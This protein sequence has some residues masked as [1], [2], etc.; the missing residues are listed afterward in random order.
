MLSLQWLFARKNSQP[1]L[2]RRSKHPRHYSALAWV[3]ALTPRVLLSA[4]NP[5]S[6]KSLNGSNGFRIHGLDP[7]HYD[8]RRVASAGDVNGD[9]FDD[10]IIQSILQEQHTNGN[11]RYVYHV[12]FG[13]PEGFAP[14]IELSSLNGSNGFRLNGI[15]SLDWSGC[16][17][18]S[19][20]DVNGDGFDDL[21][22]GACAG[23]SGECYL[24]F[25]KSSGFAPAMDISSFN[26]SNG[27]R[28]D[29]FDDHAS[30]GRSVGGAGDVN[31]DGFDDLII[32]NTAG[33]PGTVNEYRGESYVVFGK[34]KG[35][36][37]AMNLSSLNGSNGFQ[38]NGI[39]KGDNSGISV[40]SAGDVNGDGFD[41]LIIGAVHGDAGGNYS[42]ESY[43]VFGRSGSFPSKFDLSSL[44]GNNGFRLDGAEENDYSGS[45]VRSAGDMNGDGFDDL[46]IGVGVVRE[47]ATDSGESYVVFGKSSGFESALSLSTLDGSN[48]FRLNGIDAYDRCGFSVSGAGDV[49]GDGFDDL[50]I[51]APD[52]TLMAYDRGVKIF[53]TYRCGE[54]YIVYGKPNGYVPVLNLSTLD[55]FNG[56]RLDGAENSQRLG[57]SVSGGGDVNG[58]GFDDLIILAVGDNRWERSFTGDT[59]VVFGGNFTGG[60]E[61]QLG[62]V[63]ANTLTAQ[64]GSSLD[65]LIG[66]GGNDSLISDGGPD[67]LIGGQGNDI[68]AVPDSAFSS[69]RRLLGGNGTDTLRVDGHGVNLDLTRIQDNRIVDIEVV[70][71]T[72][73]GSNSLTLDAGEVLKISSHSNTLTVRRNFDDQVNI[74]N[75][76]ILGS[77]TH[78]GQ[79]S[80]LV[81]TQGAAKLLVQIPNV[82]IGTNDS[83]SFVLLYSNASASGTV[84]VTRTTNGRPPVNLGSFPMSSGL[85]LIGL[86]GTDLVRIVGTTGNDTITALSSVGMIVNGS[87]LSLNSIES[88]TLA[89]AA[90]NDIYKFDV[91]TTLGLFSLDESEGGTDTIDFSLTTK[92]PV[93]ISLANYG[94]QFVHSTNLRLNLGSSTSFENVIGGS[95]NDI[96]VG[97][98]AGNR[99]TG[100]SGYNILVG[101]NGNDFL[102]TG[103]GRDVLIGGLGR[104][105]LNGGGGDDVVI[106]G[107]TSFDENMTSLNVIRNE[108]TS[109]KSYTH[110]V[111]S[112]RTGVGSP[113]VSLR[114]KA[115]VLNDANE[116]DSLTGGI[117]TDWYFRAVDDAVTDLFAGEAIEV[118]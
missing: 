5:L 96:L 90:G 24:L 112:L 65:V 6:V 76:W 64:K 36:S 83:D 45:C 49:N 99:L 47:G 18:Q 91:D 79:D 57:W 92:V 26:G 93:N 16:D 108:W 109:A 46:I 30:T 52:A 10:V 67:V 66:G 29:G 74:G 95:Q 104:D 80:F 106:A 77:V 58:D 111:S 87:G 23:G 37:A 70:D 20:G 101:L 69:T 44:N 62:G 12:V 9:G 28:F 33:R 4:T 42:G 114:S 40:S 17:V 41:D 59:N 50:I 13:R 73:S 116:S 102:S 107:R 75:G 88:R 19:A 7:E 60:P 15:V 53:V 22:L 94:T 85:A 38:I 81:F 98:A 105:T 31:G 86:G 97:N 14:D 3:E 25:G 117:G 78:K 8:G 63:L 39:D 115:Y 103:N 89:G 84:T 118:L 56:F 61:T 27:V 35:F 71:I 21:I 32:G 48:G 2:G 51:G 43:V 55:G 113:L 82:V 1:C 68:L 110:R 100:G 72:G 11:R 54:S 34:S